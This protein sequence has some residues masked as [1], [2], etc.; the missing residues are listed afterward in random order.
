VTES[1]LKKVLQNELQINNHCPRF[2]RLLYYIACL[3]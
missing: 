3:Q 1:H 2:C